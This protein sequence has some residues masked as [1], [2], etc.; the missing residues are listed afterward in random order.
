MNPCYCETCR[1]I[2]PCHNPEAEL[3]EIEN[4]Q[5]RERLEAIANGTVC[6]SLSPA[7]LAAYRDSARAALEDKNDTPPTL[8]DPH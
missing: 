5:L 6:S 1:T 2:D 3:L 7:V 8:K 4:K